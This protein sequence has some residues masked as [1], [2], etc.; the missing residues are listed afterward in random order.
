VSVEFRVLMVVFF[1]G[2]WL[3]DFGLRFAAVREARKV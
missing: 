1:F 3:L 2:G